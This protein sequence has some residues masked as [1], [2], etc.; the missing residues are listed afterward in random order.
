MQVFWAGTL[1]DKISPP[2]LHTIMPPSRHWRPWMVPG[3]GSFSTPSWQ[4]GT[5]MSGC[6]ALQRSLAKTVSRVVTDRVVT[7]IMHRQSSAYVVYHPFDV[8]LRSH[9]TAIVCPLPDST[10]YDVEMQKQVPRRQ[11]LTLCCVLSTYSCMLRIS[12][13]L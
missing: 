5:V 1:C 3:H 2:P 11:A 9:Y 8:S 12:H 4:Q 6:R 10:N 7:G 13:N